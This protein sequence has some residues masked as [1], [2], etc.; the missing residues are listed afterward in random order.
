MGARRSM[1]KDFTGASNLLQET[2]LSNNC[3]V[4][5]LNF[6][7]LIEQQHKKKKVSVI[8]QLLGACFFF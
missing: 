2:G 4:T 5:N 6:I 1:F 8:I 7:G 3:D